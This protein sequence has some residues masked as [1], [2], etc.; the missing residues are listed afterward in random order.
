M[1]ARSS[2]P[3]SC[4]IIQ[5]SAEESDEPSQDPDGMSCLQRASLRALAG[6]LLMPSFGQ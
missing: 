3:A 2:T 5:E 6:S 1:S 4:D